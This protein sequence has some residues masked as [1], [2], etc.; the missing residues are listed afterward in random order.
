MEKDTKF[1]KNRK[2]KKILNKHLSQEEGQKI[3]VTLEKTHEIDENEHDIKELYYKAVYYKNEI[4]DGKLTRVKVVIYQDE[5]KDILD[6]HTKNFEIESMKIVLSNYVLISTGY[7]VHEA[8]GL[9][10][11]GYDHKRDPEGK[12]ITRVYKKKDN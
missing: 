6:K 1:I 11:Y 9:R 5:M 10:L 12:E 4:I 3:R 2:I 7:R 8:L